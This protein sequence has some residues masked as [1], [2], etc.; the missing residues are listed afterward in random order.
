MKKRTIFLLLLV[1]TSIFIGCADKSKFNQ[2]DDFW[3]KEIVKF[4][5]MRDMDRAD[6]AFTSLETEHIHSPILPT[7]NLLMIQAHIKQENYLLASYYMDRYNTLFG[8]KESRE[9]IEYLRIKS[10]YLGFKRP[11]RDQKLLLDALELIDN[12]LHDYPTSKYR[13]YI[14]TM[15]TNLTL[16]KFEMSLDIIKLYKKLDKPEAVEYY[17]SREDMS[18]FNRD[19]IEQPDV[20]LIRAIFE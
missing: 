3:Y 13:A 4:V 20:S 8:T 18:W 12:Y 17:K 14:E 2:S 6:E 9:Y 5:E 7:A 11:K 19:E 10:K 16:A 1:L 15:K